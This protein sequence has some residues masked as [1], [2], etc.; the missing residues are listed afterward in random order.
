MVVQGALRVWL[1]RALSLGSHIHCRNIGLLEML[2]G[3]QNSSK[4]VVMKMIC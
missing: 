2:Q 4:N 1:Q 3:L